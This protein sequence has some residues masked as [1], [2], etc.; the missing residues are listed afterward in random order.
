LD[1][2][3][4]AQPAF[5]AVPS[6]TEPV[7]RYVAGSTVETVLTFR[8]TPAESRKAWALKASFCEGLYWIWP[9]L[10]SRSLS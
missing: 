5:S 1:M 3:V 4:N 6:A 9:C 8:D 7:L 10:N 2:R